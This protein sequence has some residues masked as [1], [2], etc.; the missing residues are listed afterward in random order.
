M[1]ESEQEKERKGIENNDMSEE[2]CIES[3]LS[4]NQTR[5]MFKEETKLTS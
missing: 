3:K 5:W 1:K 2:S 4:F